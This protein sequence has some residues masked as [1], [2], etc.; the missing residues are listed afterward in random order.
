M[1]GSAVVSGA[2]KAASYNMLLQLGLRLTTFVLN[3]FILRYVSQDVLGIV[4][5]RLTLL[6]STTLF[7]TK[8]AFDRACLSK[9]TTSD[10]K[11]VINLLWC[12]FP[13]AI[14]FS[15][16][17]GMVWLYVLENPSTTTSVSGYTFGVVCFALSTIIEV[18]AEPLFVV[19]QAFLFVRL[20]VV[21][22]G[23]SQGIKCIITVILVLKQPQWGIVNFSIAQVVS[24]VTYAAM[25]HIYF[26]H[27]I[28]SNKKKAEDFPLKSVAD[29][30]PCILT[31]KPFIDVHLASLTW[32]FFKQSFLKQ[33][34]T[35]GEKF[36]MT[37]FDVLSY[38]DQG[39][40]DVVSNLGSLA[41]R[42]IFLPIEENSYLLFSKLMQRGVSADKQSQESLRLS[43]RVLGVVL[44][45]V[46]IIGSIILIFGFSNSYLAL[47]IYGGDVLSSG[48]GP[49]LL[50]WHCLYVLIIAI[51]GTTEAF[52]F[53]AMSKADVDRYNKKMVLFSGLFLL[54]SWLLTRMLGSV[55]FILANCFNMLARIAHSIYFIQGYLF[56]TG[57][58]PLNEIVPSMP[59]IVSLLVSLIVTSTSEH[60]FCREQSVIN[61]LV[62]ILITGVC[63]LVVLLIVLL[64][65]KNLI[66]LVKEQMSKVRGQKPKIQEKER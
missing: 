10:W 21:L 34:L 48:A 13:L 37:F 2:A 47:H 22:L 1:D 52:V 56:G 20:K 39:V 60:L 59:V 40:Y 58:S 30:Y 9:S 38:G 6:Y 7:L 16:C 14:L 33:I 4:N 11:Q 12:T 66:A 50:R 17:L 53:A 49:T 5:V 24:S 18:L 3:A 28:S 8:E 27:Y 51:N 61:K 64:T 35:E 46:T 19:G 65:E 57:Y 45:I 43:V 42:F 15:G 63:L 29:M 55:G 31:D 26:A 44:K 23:I 54:S 36:V 25:Y 32:S 41:A 62:H